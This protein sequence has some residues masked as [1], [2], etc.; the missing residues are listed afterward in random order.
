MPKKTMPPSGSQ[1]QPDKFRDLARELECDED[2]AKFEET[3]KRVA[4][5]PKPEKGKKPE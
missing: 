1:P 3:V 2:E 5:T 4:K